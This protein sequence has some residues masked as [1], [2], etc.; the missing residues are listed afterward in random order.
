MVDT[1]NEFYLVEAGDLCNDIAEEHGISRANFD[2][3]NPD[4]RSDCTGL[5]AEYYVCVGVY[6]DPSPSTTTTSGNSPP[7]TTTGGGPGSTPTPTQ[8]GMV[9]G[10]TDFYM[11]KDGDGCWAIADGAGISLDE[12]YAWNLAIGNDCSGLLFG[13]YVCVGRQGELDRRETAE[14]VNCVT[15]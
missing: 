12:F 11:V 5:I 8:T 14:C 15:E 9:S 1:C 2:A 3:W 10:C 13:F 7:T 6:T 4:V